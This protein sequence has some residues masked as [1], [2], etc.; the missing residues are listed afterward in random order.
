M[1]SSRSNR[2]ALVNRPR[3]GRPTLLGLGRR[4][5]IDPA[6]ARR[7]GTRHALFPGPV[8]RGKRRRLLA[9]RQHAG[10]GAPRWR[11]QA[12]AGGAPGRGR[13]LEIEACGRDRAEIPDDA[14]EVVVPGMISRKS[15]ERVPR[16]AL[17]A[18]DHEAQSTD[19][20]ARD[21][22]L[23]QRP[24]TDRRPVVGGDRECSK[25]RGQRDGREADDVVCR[26]DP[27]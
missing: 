22:C 20:A 4:G 3:L 26:K 11:R 23:V 10:R 9:R 5:Q 21:M 24:E 25:P 19:H 8:A 13:G 14:G 18:D 27:D 2:L 15:P 17:D 1:V 16:L 7:H 6:L 12:L